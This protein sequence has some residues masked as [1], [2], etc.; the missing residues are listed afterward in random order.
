[1]NLSTRRDTCRAEFD[2]VGNLLKKQPLPLGRIRKH[3]NDA[4]RAAAYRKRKRDAAAAA[5]P[6]AVLPL[7]DFLAELRREIT[8]RRAAIRCQRRRTRLTLPGPSGSAGLDLTIDLLKL[9]N[10]IECQL[11][12]TG[13]LGEVR[14]KQR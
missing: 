1:M 12:R 13:V 5:V 2:V 11:D 7:L 9:V 8:R 14:Q 10:W 3:A 6:K 4:A